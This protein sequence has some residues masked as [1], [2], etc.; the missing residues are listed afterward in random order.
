MKNGRESS[1]REYDGHWFQGGR[2][3]ESRATKAGKNCYL[4]GTAGAS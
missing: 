4:G 3:E 1:V 2:G